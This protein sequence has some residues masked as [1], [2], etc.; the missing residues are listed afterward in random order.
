MFKKININIFLY[1]K[2]LCGTWISG[3]TPFLFNMKLEHKLTFIRSELLHLHS[4]IAVCE[5]N[6]SFSR[7]GPKI[8]SC[9]MGFFRVLK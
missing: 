6:C 8:W 9:A 2:L 1:S 4:L 7:A 3:Y 5:L